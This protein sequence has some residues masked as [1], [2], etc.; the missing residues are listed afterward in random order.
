MNISKKLKLEIP[1]DLIKP[2]TDIRYY[3]FT[4]VPKVEH[5]R[6]HY[7]HWLIYI[8]EDSL[9]RRS[10][11]DQN[12]LQPII[13]KLETFIF[14]GKNREEI[15]QDHKKFIW[16]IRC[17]LNVLSWLNLDK[18]KKEQSKALVSDFVVMDELLFIQSDNEIYP[19]IYDYSVMELW[20]ALLS[21]SKRYKK[22][23]YFEEL[24][25][26]ATALFL[27]CSK[28]MIF[29]CDNPIQYDHAMFV[30]EDVIEGIKYY[31]V[32]D[33]FIME[34]E[35]LFFYIQKHLLIR[36]EI[37]NHLSHT[38]Y[39]VTP[40]NVVEMF[41]KLNQKLAYSSKVIE[42]KIFKEL[43]EWNLIIGERERYV[44]ED[45]LG[46][47]SGFSII[48]MYRPQYL[49]EITEIYDN[50]VFKL[51][52]QGCKNYID[53]V[54]KNEPRGYA[55]D[56]NY[57]MILMEITSFHHDNTVACK[58]HLDYFTFFCDSIVYPFSS[59]VFYD[60]DH[61]SI[62]QCFGEWFVWSPKEKKNYRSFTFIECYLMWVLKM[63]EYRQ[64]NLLVQT[65]FKEGLE[66]LYDDIFTAKDMTDRFMN[67]LP[68]H[69]KN[70]N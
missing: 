23:V 10:K 57:E 45:R 40:I 61:P 11:I 30:K 44:K 31:T 60:A 41:E 52:H 21:L 66:N 22:L 26:Y 6:S 20:V 70:K 48:S 25:R 69:Y 38:K 64:N 15:S 32:K 51:Y 5:E 1:P 36:K 67:L 59:N 12:I 19:Y 3:T 8:L 17:I 34:T 7:I 37:H 46:E 24:E 56:V 29:E 54:K 49:K 58:K 16:V 55:F 13:T 4:D 28:Y 63:N 9:E 50:N 39:A 35:R 47:S 62:I 27:S 2:I 14:T 18:E 53:K 43:P 42:K 33:E 68:E 65:L